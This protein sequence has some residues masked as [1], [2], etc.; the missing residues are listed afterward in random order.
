[1]SIA[2]RIVAGEVLGSAKIAVDEPTSFDDV[3]GVDNVN[4]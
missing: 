4:R 2:L 1:M 3:T